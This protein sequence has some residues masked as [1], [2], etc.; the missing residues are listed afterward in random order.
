[1]NKNIIFIFSDQQRWDTMGIYGQKLDTTPNLD[2]LGKEST[3]FDNAFTCQPVCGPARASLQT[4]LYSTKTDVFVNAIPLNENIKTIASYF[5][6]NGYQTAYVGKWH[7]ASTGIGNDGSSEDYIYNPIPENRRGGYKDYWVVSDALELTSHGFGG[8]L[9]DKDMKKVEFNKYRVDAVTDYAI[10]F[11]DNREKDKP[12]FLFISYLEPHHQND[13]RR[14]EGPE[15]SKEKFSN[16]ELPKDIESLGCG[17]AKE[18]YADYLGACHSIDYNFGR[19]REKLE[20]L[21]IWDN[22]YIVY[23]SD[24]GSHF[25]TR[26]KNMPK[27]GQDDY[28]RTS[29]DAAIHIPLI[30]KGGEFNTGKREEKFVSLI[31]LPP[32][33]LKMAGIKYQ[34]MDEISIQDIIDD[35]NYKNIV[36]LQI[37]ESFVG[38]AIRTEDYSY[39]IYDPDKNPLKDK[40]SLTY[41]SYSLYDL[42][43]DP[44]QLN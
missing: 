11:L 44:Y 1:M 22:T 36:F 5:S 40:D 6:D 38:R 37:S 41:K 3:I 7:L 27:N 31:N 33:L 23:T 35:K 16:F 43:K 24:H 8:Y 17:D 2:R 12:F 34:D 19:I 32:T 18:N 26:N 15:Y 29:E 21:N 4:G 13:K 42:K 39:C 30:I 25:R 10:D 14:Y 9:F 28:K 20:K